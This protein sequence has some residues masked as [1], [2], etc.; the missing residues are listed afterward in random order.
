MPKPLSRATFDVGVLSYNRARQTLDCVLSFLNE[1]IQPNIVVLDQG[2]ATAQREFLEDALRP[3]PNVRLVA[4]PENIGVAA[5]RNRLCRECYAEWIL[6]VDNDVTL[7]TAGGVGRIN[8]A[9][10]DAHNIDAFSPRILNIHENRFADRLEITRDNGHL[11]IAPAGP[12]L[13]MSNTFAGGAVILRRSL[14]L[15]DP[16]DERYFIG[17]EDFDLAL[18]EFTR[19]RPLRVNR[20]DAV[21]LAHKHMPVT[22]EPDVAS[23]RTRYSTPLIAKGFD[24]LGKK[25]GHHLFDQWEPW[26][27]NQLRQMIVAHPVAARV[28]RDR[29]T[30]VTFVLDVPNWAFDNVVKNLQR[31]IGPDYLLTIVYAQQ[32]DDA[33]GSLQ[34][35][36][37]SC[38][39]V[40]HFM[41]RADV[42]GLVSTAAAKRCAALMGVSEAEIVDR[43]CQSHITF[44]VC[45]H[46]FLT[47]EDIA[48]FRPL[49]WLSDGYCVVSPM[50]FDIYGQI[51]DYPRPSACIVNAV[52]RTLYHP[53]EPAN[54]K[55]SPIKIGWVGNSSWG[56]GQGLADAKGLT[57]IIRPSIEKLREEGVE[58]ELLT[59]D[60]VEYWRPREEVA[61]RYREMDV[62]ACASSIEGT[63]NTVLEAMAS[64]LP[65]VATRV[66]IVP[67]LFGPRQQSFIVER[68]VEA[69]VNALRQLCKDPALRKTLAQE[70]L[71]QIAAHTWE[72]R[73]PLWRRFFADVIRCAHPD[74]PNWRRFMI[75][76][77]FLTEDQPQIPAVPQSRDRTTLAKAIRF[78]RSAR[79]WIGGG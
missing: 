63:P 72:S 6:F 77:F 60:R 38:P 52:D 29:V 40:I 22:G 58:V 18:R 8:A 11:K 24:V 62:Y 43:L 15:D 71:Q 50:L 2:S 23:T 13:A 68:S 46:L 56:E 41:W 76:R 69:F 12:D 34:R 39:D 7:N 57:T 16:Y 75:A 64:G 59:L 53:A 47:E 65:I 31:H 66:G 36:V 4:L 45:D 30:R 1:D 67:Y 35:I 19:G 32:D 33:G 21:T 5:G 9:V 28:S 27:A 79:S 73:A 14:L 3:H 61:V 70:N 44:S 26:T 74:A 10:E 48:S 51:S 25:Y 54:R 17:F 49:F 20:L 37:D 78:L 42:R 55:Q